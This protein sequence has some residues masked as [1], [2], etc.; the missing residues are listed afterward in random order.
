MLQQLIEQLESS[1]QQSI[2]LLQ[3]TSNHMWTMIAAALVLL[4]Q[5]GFLLIEAGMARSKNSINV[6]QKNITD[7]LVSVSAFYLVGFG[8]M[9]GTSWGGFLGTD[10]FAFAEADDWQYTFF[11]FQ[12]V[13]AG[14]AATILSGAVAERM[15]F[16]AYLLAALFIG[17]LVYPV[18]GHWSWGNLLNS[19]NPAYLADKGFIDFAGSTV[20]HS[21]GGWVALAGIV[22]L[23][24]RHGKFNADGS[25]NEIQG[26]SYV[27]ATVGAIILWV[28]WIGFNGGS[29][30]TADPAFAHIIL[31]TI[32]AA[33]F[34]GVAGLLTGRVFD[35]VNIPHRPINGSL[36]GLVAI[37]AGCDVV[38][39]YGAVIIGLCAGACVVLSE[40]VIERV[41]KLD[42][43]VGAVSVHGVCGA[44]GTVMLAFFAL[45]GKLAA[46]SP[47]AQ[48][49]VQLEGVVLSFVWAFGASLIFFKLL[50]M[51]IGV[52]VP[53]HDE[54]V[55][56]NTTEHGATL[57]TG[58][59][60][61]QLQQM[62]ENGVD[63]S[64]RLD[65][66]TGDEAA[67]LAAL[68][69]PFITEVHHL[70]SGIEK[71]ASQMQQS[72]IGL[73]QI[74]CRFRKDASE[75][76]R[77]SAEMN[78][79]AEDV[80][81]SAQNNRQVADQILGQVS[82]ISDSAKGMSGE[83][84]A[85]SDAIG[86]L[87][88]AVQEISDN[89]DAT[90]S[91]TDEAN[92]LSAE[93]V[94]TM[95]ALSE[96]SH[97]IEVVVELIQKITM[98]TNMLAINAAVEASRAGDAGKGF[99]IVASQIRSL[100][101]ET[102]NAAEEIKSRIS[103][104]RTQSDGATSVITQVTGLMS[105][106]HEA[107]SGITEA[108]NSQRIVTQTISGR[109]ESASEQASTVAQSIQ[110]VRD[111]AETVKINAENNE[112][113]LSESAQS[114]QHLKTQAQ[115]GAHDADNLAD[116]AQ[117]ISGLSDGLNRS[118][119]KFVLE[120]KTEDRLDEQWED[121]ARLHTHSVGK[122]SGSIKRSG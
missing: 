88:Q 99:A 111:Q 71:R 108:V 87:M 84:T 46:A 79:T 72:S 29:T 1:S 106:I 85:V 55:G 52:R 25:A 51:T 21:V 116:A 102:G 80:V 91:V 15:Q 100:A 3:N 30:T 63:L 74:S 53:K 16:S 67:E 44:L 65:E 6:A 27:L 22:V 60:Q 107:V 13:F 35:S 47:G 11:V 75:T 43:V 37:T 112:R 105:S 26:H 89:T 36:G 118:I 50:D 64:R 38:T 31:N 4:M 58:A 7:F 18:S 8:L 92:H 12:A 70:V 19:E 66:S 61:A 93:A 2:D 98:Q 33:C 23:G 122:S 117:S 109:V 94:A 10:G 17:L 77:L 24:A 78:R 40:R 120:S 81:R 34:G 110:Q 45:P 119:G 62:T 73:E 97:E 48:A 14:T 39:V 103:R 114:A 82:C 9:F 115:I 90:S 96:A 86:G 83:V 68:F 32:L 59:L 49:I 20:V 121:E 42:D 41:L 28:G 104:M 95:E 57:G 76:S 5:A 113:R 56:L 101:T 54:M 69:N